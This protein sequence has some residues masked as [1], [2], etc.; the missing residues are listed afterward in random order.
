MGQLKESIAFLPFLGEFAMSSRLSFSS[1]LSWALLLMFSSI[2]W[3]Q[4]EETITAEKFTPRVFTYAE[5]DFVHKRPLI[6]S[7]ELGFRY[8]EADAF[9]VDNRLMIGS[10]VLDMQSKGSLESLYLEPIAKLVQDRSELILREGSPFTLIIDVKSEADSTYRAIRILL[11]RYKSILTKVVDGEVQPNAVTVIIAGNVARELIA[12][13]NPRF[14]GIDGRVS[15]LES[16][17]PPH[18]I[19]II[20]ARWGSHFRWQGKTLFTPTERDR[21]QSMV[22]RAHSKNRLIRFWSTPDVEVVW[23]AL[24]TAG[25]DLIGAE[26]FENLVEFAIPRKSPFEPSN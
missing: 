20:S 11:N 19:P 25:V 24:Q 7:L 13:E 26:D 18:L 21:L 1:K 3:G 8:I 23:T 5:N 16:N 15:D 22:E 2:A 9:L 12:V 6:G 10:S 17:A 4:E 14:V